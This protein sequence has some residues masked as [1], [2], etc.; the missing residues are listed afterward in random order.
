M[1]IKIEN[2]NSKENL[3]ETYNILVNEW[4]EGNNTSYKDGYIIGQIELLKLLINNEE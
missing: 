4:K 3:K 1:K 2:L